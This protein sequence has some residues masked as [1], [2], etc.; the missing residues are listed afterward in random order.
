MGKNYWI[1]LGISL[2][3]LMAYP[4]L[5]RD[6]MSSVPSEESLLER[7]VETVTE[8]PL[9]AE[10]TPALSKPAGPF[11]QKPAKPTFVQFRNPVFDITFSTLG[12]TITRLDYVGNPQDGR[13]RQL[14]YDGDPIFPGQFGIRFLRDVD[15]TQVVFNLRRSGNNKEIFEFSYEKPEHY[16]ILKRYILSNE[17]PVIFIELEIE[18]LMQ[19]ERHFPIL[20][21]WKMDYEITKGML[22]NNVEGLIRSDKVHSAD[23]NKLKKKGYSVSDDIFWAGNL[24]KYHALLIKPDWKVISADFE[25]DEQTISSE[26]KL[27]PLSI[28][29]GST[30]THHFFIYAGP[31]HYETLKRLDMGFEEVLSKGFFGLFKIWLL[32]AL[33]FFYGFTHNYGW[34]IIILTCLI[35]LA[36]TP[37]THM[38]FESM[39]KMQAIQP[40]LKA[41][42]EKYKK[43]PTKLNKEMMGLYKR[44]KV[45]PM[46]GCLPMLLQIPIFIAF[47]QVLNDAI[48]L[49][50]AEFIWWI[51]D[52]AKPD[53]LF[54]FPFSI[55]LIGDSF[56]LI[57][58][59]MI[60]SMFWQ[61]KLT[62]QAGATPEQTKMMQFMPI[63]FGF[64][65]YNMPSGLVIYWFVNNL[66]SIVHQVFI[67][68]MVVVLHHEDQD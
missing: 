62:P 9:I 35:K 7:E 56:N 45:N 36:F 12:G 52:L 16:R 1:A 42:Q 49:R 59:L 63:I 44:N 48:E 17:D 54:H 30:E 2:L 11:I 5:M 27:E 57:P 21:S 26:L 4:Y 20:F 22:P 65:F 19:Q 39:K 58:I 61:Q 33:K 24:L 67:K 13:D 6:H 64:L 28:A 41:I 53:Q 10:K 8:E 50:G 23:V 47:Y 55:P 18:N 29:P 68:R 34:A 31:K 32:I 37:L 46:G 66:L 43:D 51:H 25:A 14:F 38:S 15:L 60:G 40:K 3:I